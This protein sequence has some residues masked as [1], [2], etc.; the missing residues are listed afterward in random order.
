MLVGVALL[1]YT[2][3]IVYTEVVRA[4]LLFYLTPLWG[5]MLAR[6]YLSEEITPQRVSAMV[7]AI[8]GA[9]TICRKQNS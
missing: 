9:L 3:S 8:I 4:L 7:I 2:I 5:T 6:I 1:L